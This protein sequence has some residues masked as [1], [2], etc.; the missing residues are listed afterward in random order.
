VRIHLSP[1]ARAWAE[2][3]DTGT[4]S[5]TIWHVM[6]GCPMFGDPYFP[7]DPADFGRCYR[8]LKLIP[9]WRKR[10]PEV[11]ERFPNWKMLVENWRELT[12]LYERE[13]KT[14]RCPLLYRRMKELTRHDKDVVV[15]ERG[16]LQ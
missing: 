5:R 1:K 4:S 8:L 16:P 9:S 12:D 14:G 6:T 13:Y 7:L 2:S 15:I 3:G 10:L 11:A